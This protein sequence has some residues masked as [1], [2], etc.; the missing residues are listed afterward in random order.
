MF[1]SSSLTNVITLLSRAPLGMP[2]PL[3]GSARRE[4]SPPCLCH[5]FV[6]PARP[7]CRR[8]ATPRSATE[9]EAVFAKNIPTILPMRHMGKAIDSG[10]VGPSA[11]FKNLCFGSGYQ[12]CVYVHLYALTYL[13][14]PRRFGH[15]SMLARL[16]FAA[17][18]HDVY[19]VWVP[20]Q[21]GPVQSGPVPRVCGLDWHLRYSVV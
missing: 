9:D 5:I 3:P 17:R 19:M 14:S 15:H 4:F 2:A 21:S 7:P 1:T 20:R 13:L 10:S 6:V 12:V 11:L 18:V 8:Y 16:F